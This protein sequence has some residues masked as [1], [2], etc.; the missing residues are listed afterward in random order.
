MGLPP[1]KHWPR[2]FN[3][4]RGMLFERAGVQAEMHG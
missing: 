4:L 1:T 3:A 2:L